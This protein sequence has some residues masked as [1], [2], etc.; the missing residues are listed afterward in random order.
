MTQVEYED[1]RKGSK[2][3]YARIMAKFG[4]YEIH[5]VVMVSKNVDYCTVCETKT[6]Q[7]FI[8]NENSMYQ[9]LYMDREEALSYLRDMQKKNKGVK[10]CSKESE[11]STESEE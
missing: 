8:F 7:S 2:L 6:K 1:I 5:D 9:S 4:Y 10:V 3:Y 11:V